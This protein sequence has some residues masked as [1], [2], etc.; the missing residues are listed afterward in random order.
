M[1]RTFA[2]WL[3]WFFSST[4]RPAPRPRVE[5]DRPMK[6]E[7]ERLPDYLWR[8]LGFPATR[9]PEDDPWRQVQ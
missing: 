5:G 8:E 4:V 3:G 1:T 2:Q 6:I 9:R 7:V